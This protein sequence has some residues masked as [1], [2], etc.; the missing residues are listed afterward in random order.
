MAGRGWG[1]E[2]IILARALR[3]CTLS[4]WRCLRHASGTERHRR[5]AHC[6]PPHAAWEPALCVAHADSQEMATQ[7]LGYG[8]QPLFA[9][10]C[11]QRRCRATRCCVVVAATPTA[12][13]VRVSEWRARPVL[14][15]ES[16]RPGSQWTCAPTGAFWRASADSHACAMYSAVPPHR[17]PG[18]QGAVRRRVGTQQPE[19]VRHVR[20]G[21]PVGGGR[22]RRRCRIGRSD[23]TCVARLP[24]PVSRGVS[25]VGLPPAAF[26]P[27]LT[28]HRAHAAKSSAV[29]LASTA[30]VGAAAAAGAVALTKQ[31][32]AVAPKELFNSLVG[33][34]DPT[35]LLPEKA[36]A[37]ALRAQ[38]QDGPLSSRLPARW[39]FAQ[40]AESGYYNTARWPP[41]LPSTG[42][43]T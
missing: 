41:S 26:R 24:C 19:H 33:E 39:V 27:V 17:F 32:G 21:R 35:L 15:R 7:H 42:W 28:F 20:G 43:P 6:P 3:D 18:A 12:S 5:Q 1:W 2:H 23:C 4:N 9:R 14:P 13:E 30:V 22:R 10:P 11:A 34:T 40:G 8:L 25:A 29:R 37:P 36:R 31:R 16:R 38:L